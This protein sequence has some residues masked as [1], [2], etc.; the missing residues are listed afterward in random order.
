MI[1]PY[2][3]SSDLFRRHPHRQG[4]RSDDELL[5][6]GFDRFCPLKADELVWGLYLVLWRALPTLC[7]QFRVHLFSRTYMLDSH[8]YPSSLS[9]FS[10]M[11]LLRWVLE[12]TFFLPLL[13]FLFGSLSLL[14]LEVPWVSLF[15]PLS[16][17]FR[18]GRSLRP[19]VGFYS[20]GLYSY[21]LESSLKHSSSSPPWPLE[22]FIEYLSFS[23]HG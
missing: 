14:A 17:S 8:Y 20:L 2:Q 4:R 18:L 21:L 9:P 23:S 22:P 3:V 16:M 1:N 15:F 10:K 5:S 11:T 13:L 6:C 19:V 12:G 7:V